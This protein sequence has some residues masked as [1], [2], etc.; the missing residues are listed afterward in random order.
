MDMLTQDMAALTLADVRQAMA[1]KA[2]EREDS[3]KMFKDMYSK[4][5]EDTTLFSDYLTYI[6][7]DCDSWY[8][9][10][11]S[12][13]KSETSVSRLKSMI[14]NLLNDTKYPEVASCISVEQRK[15]VRAAM[16][17]TLRTLVT[18]GVFKPRKGKRDVVSAESSESTSDDVGDIAA[19]PGE[20]FGE[21]LNSLRLENN[22]LKE[23]LSGTKEVVLELIEAANL[24][25]A[26]K[27]FVKLLV[28]RQL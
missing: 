9:D 26:W 13:Y 5:F 8:R 3:K 20:I 1:N 16:R 15:A 28:E 14:N 7:N 10:A 2:G 21:S 4:H 22:R 25:N 6:A 12:S 11:P 23:M 17:D 24:D 19:L 27:P 18:S